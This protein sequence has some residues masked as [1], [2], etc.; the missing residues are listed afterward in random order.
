MNQLAIQLNIIV[1]L[2]RG[3][4]TNKLTSTPFT[5]NDITGINRVA[6]FEETPQSFTGIIRGSSYKFWIRI[7]NTTNSNN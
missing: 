2:F 4:T 5:V 3:T 7:C 6:F 1:P